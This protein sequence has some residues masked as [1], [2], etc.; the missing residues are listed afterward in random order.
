MYRGRS[1][2]ENSCYQGVIARRTSYTRYNPLAN[3]L[4]NLLTKKKWL[5]MHNKVCFP[6]DSPT[7]QTTDCI[8]YTIISMMGQRLDEML[9]ELK[10][11]HSFNPSSNC[12]PDICIVYILPTCWSAGW[13]NYA[14][15]PSP[16]D[17]STRPRRSRHIGD[18]TMEFSECVAVWWNKLML[19]NYHLSRVYFIQFAN[20]G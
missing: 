17:Q 20:F 13:L 18:I 1:S 19:K 16:G 6:T 14:N 4:T 5:F 3:R 10:V 8:V 7:G 9:D 11:F 15:K 2:F 12:W